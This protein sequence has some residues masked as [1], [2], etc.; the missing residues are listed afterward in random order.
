M[1]AANEPTNHAIASAP[2]AIAKWSW[3]AMR[4]NVPTTN[5]TAPAHRQKT[6]TGSP[7]DQT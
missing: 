4:D 3:S 7:C 2:D 1:I 6:L 5:I